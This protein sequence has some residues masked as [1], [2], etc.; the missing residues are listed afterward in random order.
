MKILLITDI[1]NQYDAARAAFAG[2]NPD[3]ILDCG[4]HHELKNLFE[5]TPHY[6]VHGNHEPLNVE[7]NEDDFPLPHRISS[8][9]IYEFVKEN[10]YIKFSGVGGH[11]SLKE[12][13]LSVRPE[14]VGHLK[15]ISPGGLDILLLHESPFNIT[16]DDKE[17]Y[18]FAVSVA[19]QMERISPKF[20]FAGHSGKYSESED[21]IKGVNVINLDDM[22]FGYGILDYTEG[23]FSFK[24]KIARFG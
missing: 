14:D 17:H 2:E 18:Y 11:Y 9:Q 15:K 21:L 19:E 13:S 20:V 6:Y 7:L 5:L 22:G 10:I 3:L 12:G 8:S 16:P 4:D 1:H 23:I 24:R